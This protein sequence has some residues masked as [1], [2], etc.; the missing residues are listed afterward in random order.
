MGSPL[1]P[2]YAPA[3]ANTFMG[4]L[5]HDIIN[6]A[7][8]K[9]EYYRRFIDNIFIIFEHPEELNRFIEHMNKANNSIQFTHEKNLISVTFLDVT[10]YKEENN[11]FLQY[12]THI[13]PTNKQLY[14]RHDS[15]HTPGTFK[16][17]VIGEAIRFCRTNSKPEDFHKIILKHKRNLQRR[18]F[19]I[20][21][22]NKHL[23]HSTKANE[24]PELRPTFKSRYCNK[25]G[26][27]FHIVRKHYHMQQ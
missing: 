16:G 12:T 1:A 26:K 11:P 21:L 23:T 13:K 10:L 15:H 9:P 8:H 2:A 25:T 19:P 22:I 3:C 24:P 4:K 27:V 6:S 17:V 18:R 7:T 14:V 5:E 20:N